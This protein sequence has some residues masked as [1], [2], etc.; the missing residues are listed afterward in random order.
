MNCKGNYFR[1][2]AAKFRAM[3]DF[4]TAT[5]Q[6]RL[7]F[8]RFHDLMPQIK[9][10]ESSLANLCAYSF[11]YHGEYA[12][13]EDCLAVRIYF[14][15]KTVCYHYPL[16]DGNKNEVLKLLK[17]DARE[18]GF[19]MMLICG[20]TVPPESIQGAF[21]PVLRRDFFDY[22]YSSEDLQ[23][24]KGRKYQPKRNHINKFKS[25]Y[26]WEFEVVKPE[27]VS[28][29]LA[30]E[31]KW[32]E[33]AALRHPELL[34]DYRKER[35]IVE[36]LLSNMEELGIFAGMIRVDGN[37]AAFSIGSRINSETFDTHI[38]KADR[39]LEGSFAM[40]NQQMAEHLPANFIYINREEDLG[41]EGLRKA[42]ESYHPLGLIEKYIV[43][44]R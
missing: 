15:E 43:T 20:D 22:L 16:G 32:I 26:D 37:I 35:K 44:I 25:L 19:V 2:F 33:E 28:E 23:N 3:I 18:R 12:V 1:N 14:D 7:L 5:P 6:D 24:L 36:Y 31:N 8:E 38:E 41:L 39:N 11:L 40:I 17:E 4:K 21:A 29:C 27:N 10:A 13:V 34:S 42:K 9:N 30:F